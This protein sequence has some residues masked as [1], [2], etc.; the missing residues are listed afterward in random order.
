MSAV[1][2]V[3]I[4]VLFFLLLGGSKGKHSGKNTGDRSRNDPVRIDRMHYY[5]PDDH[6]CSVCGARFVGK[7][8]VCPKC[9]ARFAGTKDEDDEFIEEMELWDDD[10]D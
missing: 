9:G 5:D 6:E 3:V 7:S 8:M 10:E 4:G 2:W 1:F